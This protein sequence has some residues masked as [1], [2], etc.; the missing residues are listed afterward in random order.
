[1][2]LPKGFGFDKEYEKVCRLKKSLYG[3]KQ[4]PLC[5]YKVVKKALM[6]MGFEVNNAENGIYSKRTGGKFVAVGL[7][8]DDLLCIANNAKVLQD[9]KTQLKK[10]FK[11]KDLGSISKFLGVRIKQDPKSKAVTMDHEQYINGLLKEFDLTEAK[12]SPCPSWTGMNIDDCDN[13][14]LLSD[15]SQYRSLVGKLLWVD[16]AFEVS[17]LSRYLSCPRECH[18]TAAKHVLRYLKGSKSWAI[19]YSKQP[20]FTITGYS[21]ADWAS[22]KN[23]RKSTTGYVFMLAG[24]PI[25]WRS[26]RQ[27]SVTLSS[28]ETEFVALSEAVKEALWL[29]LVARELG[30]KLAENF[31]IYEDNT[32]C[33]NISKNPVLHHRTKHIDTR[34]KFVREN[35]QANV[36]EVRQVESENN[37]ADMF[38]KGLKKVQ[39][40]RLC[41]LLRRSN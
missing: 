15:G 27:P 31:A 6:D 36:V 17:H 30:L 40:A 7:F 34:Y 5:W 37:I 41:D 23:T 28:A 39:F 19:Q 1:M 8:V 20:A 4:A 38:T 2:E 35:V 9:T 21:D 13:S 3:L 33:I 26:S 24:G 11:I 16:I 14:P 18:W 32:A 29:K 12:T 22:D 10:R 25:S